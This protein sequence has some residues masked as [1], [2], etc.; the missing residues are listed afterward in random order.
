M[1]IGTNRN[2]S[3]YTCE[4]DGPICCL[5]CLIIYRC[6]G[7]YK[8]TTYHGCK[9]AFP[10][11]V[12][13]WKLSSGAKTTSLSMFCHGFFVGT[14]SV[15]DITFVRGRKYKLFYATTS[16]EHGP[17]HGLL[18]NILDIYLRSQRVRSSVKL[19]SKSVYL[20]VQ[21]VCVVLRISL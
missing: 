13:N 8:Y 7:N 20:Y 2:G 16:H 15:Y 12:T 6:N 17:K 1:C 21:E 3:V 19:F 10:S 4:H 11:I 5:Q 14:L 9:S 18:T